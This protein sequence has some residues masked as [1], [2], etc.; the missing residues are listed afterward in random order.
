MIL[1]SISS[2]WSFHRWKIANLADSLGSEKKFHEKHRPNRNI[3]PRPVQTK[4]VSAPLSRET[5][6]FITFFRIVYTLAMSAVTMI[7][8]TIKGALIWCLDDG[9]WFLIKVFLSIHRL[10]FSV[11]DTESNIARS[12]LVGFSVKIDIL[13]NGCT[14]TKLPDNVS[15]YKSPCLPFIWF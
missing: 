15:L 12:G 6:W 4:S 13:P 3:R 7:V 14:K 2:R 8:S 11:Q 1:S 10:L 9:R 5:G